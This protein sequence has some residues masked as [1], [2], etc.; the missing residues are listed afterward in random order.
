MND[1]VCIEKMYKCIKIQFVQ[2]LNR[3]YIAK[4]IFLYLSESLSAEFDLIS[5]HLHMRPV[6]FFVKLVHFNF[7]LI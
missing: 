3:D 2:C 1:C 7:V 4:L 5:C 6:L